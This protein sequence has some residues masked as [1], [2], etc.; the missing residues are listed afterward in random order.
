M[1]GGGDGRVSGSEVADR[2]ETYS[3]KKEDPSSS[4]PLV[5]VGGFFMYIT[6]FRIG[7]L[8]NMYTN[9]VGSGREALGTRIA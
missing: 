5:V 3:C 6:K 8:T 2:R 4:K 9:C 1:T 7:H